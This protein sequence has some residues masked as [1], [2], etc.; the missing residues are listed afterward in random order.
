[1][2]LKQLTAVLL[3]SILLLCGCSGSGNNET[4]TYTDTLFDTVIQIQILKDGNQELLKGC[5]HICK[6]YDTMF[7]RTNPESEIYKINNADGKPVEVSADTLSIIKEGIYFSELS[8]G[9]FDITIGTVSSL[10]DFRS[11][12]KI[13]PSQDTINSSLSHINFRNIQITDNTIQLTDP[14]TMLDVGALAKGYIADKVKE[15]LV[16]NGIE[17]AI[18]DLGGNV[19]V[20]GSKTDGSDYNIGI[21]KPFDQTGIPVTSVKISDS[22]IVTTGIYQRYFEYDD[23]FY[24]HILNPDTGYPCDNNLYSVTIITDSSLKADALSTTCFL[25]GFDKGME[26]INQLDDTKAVFI[27]ND[28]ELHYSENFR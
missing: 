11:E 13:I 5:E 23:Q 1:M 26:L 7:S 6:K 21:Q 8:N 27:T 3:S 24:H 10:W 15:Y 19:L 12:D 16:D 22:S 25:L 18:I 9:T 14:D 17:H 20:I 2:K 4:L 28:Q